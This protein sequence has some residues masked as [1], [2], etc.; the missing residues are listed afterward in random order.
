[1]GYIE[2]HTNNSGG[3]WWLQT[4][5]WQALERAGWIVHWYHDA[6]DDSHEHSEP[7]DNSW[8][9]HSH[10]YSDPL[11]PATSSGKD[12]MGALA[13]SAAKEVNSIQEAEDALSEFESV[14][15]HNADSE[16]CSCCG[17]P[18]SFSYHDDK[19]KTHYFDSSPSGYNRS[20]S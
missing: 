4:S 6:N 3:S 8:S 13:T 14:T 19:G 5:H 2:Y 17:P 10:G 18:H 16:G 12:W 9:G 7:A 1:M 11:I 20:W 15:G